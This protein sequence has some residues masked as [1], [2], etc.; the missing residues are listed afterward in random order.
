[1]RRAEIDRPVFEIDDDRVDPGARHDLHG[2]D[3]GNGCDRAEGRASLP[4]E[5]AQTVERRRFGGGQGGKLLR[6]RHGYGGRYHRDK[7]MTYRA[8]LFLTH[9]IC[10]AMIPAQE[11]SNAMR[12]IWLKG[13]FHDD[14][15]TYI[16]GRR[17]RLRALARIRGGGASGAGGV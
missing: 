2:L 10:R 3:R 16:Y 7:F 12:Q 6:N 11:T 5:L 4:P 15:S 9:R 14:R 17:I 1:M 13:C 8:T